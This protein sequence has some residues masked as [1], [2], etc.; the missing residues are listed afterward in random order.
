MPD[1]APCAIAAKPF[2]PP[3]PRMRSRSGIAMVHQHFSLVS[4]MTVVDNV[5]LGQQRGVLNT[6]AWAQRL[7]S[8]AR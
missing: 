4:D 5:L 1:E 6:K 8:L 2:S 3:G 7:E